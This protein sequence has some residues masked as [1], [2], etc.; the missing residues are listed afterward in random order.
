M[1]TSL[2]EIL[3]IKKDA[4]PEEG[5][6]RSYVPLVSLVLIAL[7]VRKAYRRRALQTHPD[8]LPPNVTAAD[9]EAA[10]EQFRL[11][12]NAYEVL[13]NADNRKVRV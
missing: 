3:G 11:V 6:H 9:K 5:T 13:N 1:T 10:E 12:N 7:P 8:R 2:Y 4:T